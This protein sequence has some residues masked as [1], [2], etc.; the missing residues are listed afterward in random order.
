MHRGTYERFFVP[1]W[2][3]QTVFLIK[4]FSIAS[5][6]VSSG[7]FWVSGASFGCHW[8]NRWCNNDNEPPFEDNEQF[9]WKTGEP[10]NVTSK[11]CVAV[12]FSMNKAPHLSFFK[13]DC[14]TKFKAIFESEMRF[15]N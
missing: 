12:D 4:Q 11:E 13:A 9:P 5:K 2:S 6:K 8:D 1:S 15:N 10:S 3:W 7:Q 14:D